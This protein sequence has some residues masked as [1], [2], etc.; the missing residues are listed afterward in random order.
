MAVDVVANGLLQTNLNNVPESEVYTRE[1]TDPSLTGPF[2]TRKTPGNL[3]ASG[4]NYYRAR[5]QY[6]P[7]DYYYFSMCLDVHREGPRSL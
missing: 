4:G 6:A 1:R 3:R 5:L 7:Y 2:I